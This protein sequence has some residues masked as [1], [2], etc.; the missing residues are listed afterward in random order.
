MRRSGSSDN[1]ARRIEIEQQEKSY[2]AKIAYL[3]RARHQAKKKRTLREF[4]KRTNTKVMSHSE[5]GSEPS[6]LLSPEKG[7]EVDDVEVKVFEEIELK[8][9]NL[10]KLYKLGHASQIGSRPGETKET[11]LAIADTGSFVQQSVSIFGK[12]KFARQDVHMRVI[13]QHRAEL[14][15]DAVSQHVQEEIRRSF[16]SPSVA[17]NCL[18]RAVTCNF[19]YFLQQP[20]PFINRYDIEEYIDRFFLIN[21]PDSLS[22]SQNHQKVYL[23]LHQLLTQ[24]YEITQYDGAGDTNYPEIVVG[25]E[26]QRPNAGSP[27]LSPRK[28]ARENRQLFF[29]GSVLSSEPAQL[30]SDESQQSELRAS[31]N[32]KPQRARRGKRPAV[33]RG[34]S[35]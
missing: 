4:W 9:R 12:V 11:R 28:S 18:K 14:I 31:L 35:V 17:Y 34:L 25:A 3:R 30:L 7:E 22:V 19:Q 27:E 23:L 15:K 2:Y 13:N 21:I 1:T 24:E 8:K 10:A 29:P 20:L 5:D 6:G 33:V 26:E 32:R 16:E